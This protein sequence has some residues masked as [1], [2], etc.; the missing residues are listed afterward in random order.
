ME[1]KLVHAGT[2]NDEI[3]AKKERQ[4]VPQNGMQNAQ[5][6]RQNVS[7]QEQKWKT[8]CRGSIRLLEVKQG[9]II[10]NIYGLHNLD[11]QVF[12]T[13]QSCSVFQS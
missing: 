7:S 9:S 6:G 13:W 8:K 1:A 2:R 3:L 11:A 4:N 5:N 10:N 12:R